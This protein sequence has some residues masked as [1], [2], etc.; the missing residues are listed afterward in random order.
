M[1][2]KPTNLNELIEFRKKSALPSSPIWSSLTMDWSTFA[3][4]RWRL[5]TMMA[6]YQK[7]PLL[8][9][10]IDRIANAITGANPLILRKINKGAKNLE[11]RGLNRLSVKALKAI[12]RA[13]DV[14]SRKT[15]GDDNELVEDD[16][17]GFVDA[18]NNKEMNDGLSHYDIV[19]LTIVN[20]NIYG[21]AFILK[22]REGNRVAGYKHL[23]TF[24]MMP[25]RDGA[26]QVLS[27]F[28]SPLWGDEI[29]KTEIDTNDLLIFRNPSTTDPVAG[30][31]SPVLAALAKLELSGKWQ[32]YQNWLLGN[33]ARP[34]SIFIPSIPEGGTLSKEQ[35]QRIEKSVNDKFRG[36]GNGRVAI[37]DS[38]GKLEILNFSP[39]DLAPIEF[40][41]QLTQ[42]LLYVL[43]I[44]EALYSDDANRANASVA[45]ENF[46]RWS[47]APIAMVVERIMSEEARTYDPNL[48]YC[49]QNIIPEDVDTTLAQEKADIDKWNFALTSGAIDKNEY[50]IQ[51]LGLDPIADLAVLESPEKESVEVSTTGEG[52]EEN[53]LVEDAGENPQDKSINDFD[54]LSL[55]TKVTEGK[56]DRATAINIVSYSLKISQDDAKNLVTK[57]A[58]KRRKKKIV[59][60]IEIVE[61]KVEN[62]NEEKVQDNNDAIPIEI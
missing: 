13:S 57:L 33:R 31:D 12:H 20:L 48:V 8:H 42:C 56:L 17:N 18:L 24:N 35:A 19:R 9:G 11:S 52:E 46:A 1:S 30:G 16:N 7:N 4:N 34:D 45:K 32:D 41:K 55:N 6:L 14:M 38:A 58:K 49:F 10:S 23:P 40:D 43:N 2:N 51:I 59:E 62:N 47:L 60:P 53:E 25:N 27:W 22:E 50:R 28:Y 36:Q 44:P 26:G 21:I 61:E 5:W 15:I 29:D 3:T 37:A 54:L 39:M